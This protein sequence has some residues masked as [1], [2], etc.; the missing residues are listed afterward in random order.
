MV[1]KVRR[2][3][4][5]DY[6]TYAEQRETIRASAMRAKDLRRVHA[7]ELTYLFENHETVR[8]QVQEMMRAEQ[9]VK[10]AE[11]QHELETYNELLGDDGELGATLLLEIEDPEKRDTKLARWLDLPEKCYVSLADGRRIYATF[12]PRQKGDDRLSSVQFLKFMTGGEIPIAIGSD[13][14]DLTNETILNEAQREA[15]RIDLAG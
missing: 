4:I 10:E 12:D 7:G 5:L 8:Y 2:E 6:Q 13:H 14:P 9:L 11:I 1:N 3:E 15:L